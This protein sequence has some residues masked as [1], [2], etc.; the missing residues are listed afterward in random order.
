[1]KK[2]IS[3]YNF[4]NMSTDSESPDIIF[5]LNC[6]K[7]FIYIAIKIQKSTKHPI[8]LMILLLQ[9]QFFEKNLTGGGSITDCF[10]PIFEIP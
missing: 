10:E 3:F 7:L 2:F 8:F 9:K 5:F 4:G 1:M 6:S